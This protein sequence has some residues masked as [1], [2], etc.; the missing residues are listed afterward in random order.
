MKCVVTG[1]SGFIGSH[2][3]DHLL[4]AGWQVKVLDLRRPI[5][6]VEWTELDIRH[7]L[8]RSLAGVDL[9]FHLAALANARKCGEY[10]DLCIATNVGGT[11]NVLRAAHEFGVARVVLASSCWVAGAQVG[12]VVDEDS[13]FALAAVNT[14]YGASKIAQEMLCFSCHGEY[15]GPAYTILRY[16]I[17]YGERMWKGL[18]V[19][20]FMYQS[21]TN[22][23][24]SI[25]GDGKQ[26]REF[27]YVGDLCEAQLLAA[28]P[29][30]VNKTYNL[31]GPVPVT[32]E[33]LAKEVVKLLP[34]SIDYV[35]QARIE[36]KLRH[37]NN[38]LARRELGWEPRTTLTDGIERCVSWWKSL[39]KE[40]K[41]EEYWC[42]GGPEGQSRGAAR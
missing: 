3:V 38:S 17:P 13:P 27:L 41:E 22:H 1:G 26:H 16:G 19:R 10:P 6:N 34:A 25:M 32:V 20:E 2:L 7:D 33:E 37:V 39:S 28:A 14:V 40:A 35:P 24:I 23:R 42:R 21:E 30:A 29:V 4:D 31:T 11:L 8:G 5:Q 9:V 12:D 15:G 36:P 18:V